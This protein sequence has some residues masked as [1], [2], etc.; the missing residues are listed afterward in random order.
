MVEWNT[1]TY[2]STKRN[3]QQFVD[4]VLQAMGIKL[5]VEGALGTFLPSLKAYFRLF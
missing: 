1:R 2:H 4:D 5:E 3:C